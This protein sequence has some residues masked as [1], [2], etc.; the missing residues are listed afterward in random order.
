MK[1]SYY[2]GTIK[3]EINDK[4]IKIKEAVA[5]YDNNYQ[6]RYKLT[7]DLENSG[8]DTLIAIMFNPSEKSIKER[9][10]SKNSP[11]DLTCKG[12]K[13]TFIDG[14]ITNVIKIANKCNYSKIVI[15]NLFSAI[16]S[17]PDDILKNPQKYIDKQ[18]DTEINENF[19]TN[20][21]ILIAWG[22]HKKKLEEIKNKWKEL[23]NGELKCFCRNRDKSPTHPSPHNNSEVADFLKYENKL[24]SI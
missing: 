12:K 17:S 24:K 8:K 19:Q 14:T 9:Y 23:A 6:K 18:N 1:T 15:L 7:V 11:V 22:S 2:I 10:S 3:D 13:K 4:T 5:I 16:N 21:D 20:N